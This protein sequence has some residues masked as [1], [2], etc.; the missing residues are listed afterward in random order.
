M[1][2]ERARQSLRC[3]AP[4]SRESAA[5]DNLQ[6]QE[7]PADIPSATPS[8]APTPTSSVPPTLT[9]RGSDN[10]TPQSATS[11]AGNKK[12]KVV[13]KEDEDEGKPAKRSKISYGRG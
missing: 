12:K 1:S 2:Q 13:E 3:L 9:A 5:T 11:K 4:G 8:H 10:A 6:S 7:S